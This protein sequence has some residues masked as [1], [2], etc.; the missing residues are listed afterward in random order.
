MR[1][2]VVLGPALLAFTLVPI[3]GSGQTQLEPIDT[4]TKL[5]TPARFNEALLEYH[6]LAKQAKL[7]ER[8]GNAEVTKARGNFDPKL[9]SDLTAKTFKGTSYY[10]VQESGMRIPTWFGIDLKLYHERNQGAFLNSERTVPDDGLY[11]IGLELPIGEGLFTD[12]R[13]TA[14][15]KAKVMRDVKTNKRHQILMK[16]LTKGFRDYWKWAGLHQRQ[17]VVS[18]TVTTAEQRFRDVKTAFR[19]GERTAIDTTEAL[20]QLQQF[21]VKQQELRGQYQQQQAKLSTYL[22]DEDQ[23]PRALNDMTDP[24]DLTSFELSTLKGLVDEVRDMDSVGRQHPALARYRN[25]LELL[26]L[27]NQWKQEQLKPELDLK[28]HALQNAGNTI[29]LAEQQANDNLKWGFSFRF[30]IFL[31]KERGSLQLNE[32]KQRSTELQFEQQ[33]LALQRRLEGATARLQQLYQQIKTNQ[34]NLSNF[35]KLLEAERTLYDGGESSLLRINLR[36]LKYLQAQLK[37]IKYISQF[38]QV[39]SDLRY[40]ITYQRNLGNTSQN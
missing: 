2:F 6:P 16:L 13:R 34:K 22:W 14:L 39:Y 26:S 17:Q 37:H 27:E 23:Q 3:T 12:E 20:S 36:E 18:R 24:P 5:L 11:G 10:R 9:F 40:R 30:P 28:Y 1:L 21:R 29:N 8:Q 4:A 38:F 32:L 35:Q 15:N 33:Q 25:Q 19:G 7:V 31:R